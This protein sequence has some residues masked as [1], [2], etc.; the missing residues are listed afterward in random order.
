MRDCLEQMSPSVVYPLLCHSIIEISWSG[1]AF[2]ESSFRSSVL[3]E[4]ASAEV[5][6]GFSEFIFFIF[7]NSLIF[8]FILMQFDF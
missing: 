4:K 3:Q 8:Y 6:D 1:F 5:Y 2:S 7:M